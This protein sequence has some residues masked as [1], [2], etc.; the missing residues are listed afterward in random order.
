M[1]SEL[2][3]L[4][5]GVLGILATAH[6]ITFAFKRRLDPSGESSFYKNL[7]A[8]IN[9][10][11]AMVIVLVLAV[12][13][14]RIATLGIFALISF[15]AL[16]EF[17]T[18]TPTRHGDHRSLWW[19][20]FFI[21]P[22]QY[23]AIALEMEVM[24]WI[25]IPVYAFI[26]IPVR[27]A[28][29]EDTEDF[30]SRTAK[31]QW[32]LMLCVYFVSHGP[33]LLLIDIPEYAGHNMKLLF[34]LVLIVQL[35]DVMQYVWGK[36]IGKTPISAKLSPN[37]TVEGLVGGIVTTSLIGSLLW[38]ATPFSM[39]AAGVIS[40]VLCIMGFLGGVVMSAIKRDR[41]IKDYGTLLPGHGGVMDRIDSLCFA[42]PV[43]YRILLFYYAA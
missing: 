4:I 15:Q 25:F 34:F 3:I 1:D 38:W 22:A 29:A 31:V 30:L 27:S 42:A 10:W 21:L 7:V 2:L 9:A 41:G 23:L 16:R 40:F 26:F 19:S 11:W 24:A 43:F 18:I 32:G 5:L 28:L 8:R 17:V 36:S 13:C 35:S 20:F 6:L 14:G 39:L 37:K 33:A 12:L